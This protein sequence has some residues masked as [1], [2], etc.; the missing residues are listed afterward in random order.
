MKVKNPP[1]TPKACST[2][3]S[4][5][6]EVTSTKTAIKEN[7]ICIPNYLDQEIKV[8]GRFIKSIT[9]EQHEYTKK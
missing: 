7:T 4:S 8:R 3:S 9:W 5:S 2:A 1:S 6:S